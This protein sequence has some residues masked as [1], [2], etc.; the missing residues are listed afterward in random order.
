MNLSVTKISSKFEQF[1]TP[2]PSVHSLIKS[3]PMSPL[4]EKQTINFVMEDDIEQISK[5]AEQCP[6]FHSIMAIPIM[7]PFLIDLSLLLLEYADENISL[8]TFLAVLAL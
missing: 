2:E 7:L 6:R 1:N 8:T 3:H 5:E 4:S